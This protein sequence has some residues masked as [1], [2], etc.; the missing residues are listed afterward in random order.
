MDWEEEGGEWD[1]RGREVVRQNGEVQ[2]GMRDSRE[3]KGW[4]EGGRQV[5]ARVELTKLKTCV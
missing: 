1:S 5:K 3:G 4:S 2:S